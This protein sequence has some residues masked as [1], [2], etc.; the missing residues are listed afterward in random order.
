MMRA[1]QFW[2]FGLGV[3]SELPV[4]RKGSTCLL[5]SCVPGG[6]TPGEQQVCM[7]PRTEPQE[8]AAALC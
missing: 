3:S 2:S 8:P 6:Q 1:W 7:A 4:P 5:A